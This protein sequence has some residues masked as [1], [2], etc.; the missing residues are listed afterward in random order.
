MNV[1]RGTTRAC[2][3]I[4]PYAIKTPRL[5]RSGRGLL[6]SL[7]HGILANLSEL[8]LSDQ[9]GVAPV[10][11]S[12]AGIVNVYPRCQPLVGPVDYTRIASPVVPVDPRPH[13]VGV[14]GGRP[15]WL[16]YARHGECVACG[17]HEHEEARRGRR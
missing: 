7:A 15:V 17:R 12:L 6:W 8:G 4:G 2:L 13:N 9:P 1:R 5:A 16:D 14:L 11:W 3:L 10:L